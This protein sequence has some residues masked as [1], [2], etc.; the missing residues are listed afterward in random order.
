MFALI[1]CSVSAQAPLFLQPIGTPLA[2]G[3]PT[4]RG[5]SSAD[6]N[7]DGKKDLVVGCAYDNSL[8][9]YLGSG[10]GQFSNAPG[11]PMVIGNGTIANTISDFNGDLIPDLAI[12]NY[13]G[14][15]I[16]ILLGA[17]NGSFTSA[18][19]ST[20]ATG[21]YPYSIESADFNNDGK[22]DFVTVSA[23]ANQAYV[24]LGNGNGTFTQAVGSP[25]STGAMPYHVCTGFFNTDAFIDF[26]VANF[27]DSNLNIFLGNG[28][29]GFSAGPGSPY[30]VGT[31]P[32]TVVTKDINSDGR[33][34]LVV[35]NSGSNNVSIL[36][37]QANGSFTNAPVPT[38]TTG[39][40]AFQAAIADF[41]GDSKQD[42]AVSN[43]LSSD[44]ALFWGDGNGN[45]TAAT[46]TLAVSTNPQNMITDDFNNDGK[47]DLAIAHFT[48]DKVTILINR[49]SVGIQESVKD[50]RILI[51]PIPSHNNQVTIKTADLEDDA[52]FIL[53]DAMGQ[54][55]HKTLLT[56]EETLIDFGSISKGIYPYTI[57]HKGVVIGSGKLLF[58]E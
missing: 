55:V 31:A 40:Y 50:N 2:T 21:S 22:K 12:A 53:Y 45:F 54:E 38:F 14:G 47:P 36:L 9:I 49:T 42:L 13:Y 56:S 26:T 58:A 6:L 20:I 37:G 8:S 32:R 43:A 4:L 28:S 27:T 11:S 44:I 33:P 23:G 3:T 52:Y 48:F 5:I 7:A 41:N 1:T 35:A 24:F 39:A 18:S 46:P 10:N 16:S 19:T 30:T 51:F 57:F 17:G 15:Y 29:G 25:L 34:D